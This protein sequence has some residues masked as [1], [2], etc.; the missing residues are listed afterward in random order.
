[1]V[2]KFYMIA[3]IAFMSSLCFPDV[4]KLKT[5]TVVT[6]L[7]YDMGI[8][9]RNSCVVAP[10]YAKNRFVYWNTSDTNTA[11]WTAVLYSR[12]ELA[13]HYI[14]IERRTVF[15]ISDFSIMQSV[16]YLIN[17]VCVTN[18][19]AEVF[20]FAVEN[21]GIR[22]PGRFALVKFNEGGLFLYAVYVNLATGKAGLDFYEISEANLLLAREVTFPYLTKQESRYQ[23]HIIKD[24]KNSSLQ[25]RKTDDGHTR[26]NIYSPQYAPKGHCRMGSAGYGCFLDYSFGRTNFCNDSA[27]EVSDGKDKY[28][29]VTNS[30]IPAYN[31]FTHVALCYDVNS[32]KL[33]K[34]KTYRSLSPEISAEECVKVIDSISKNC[35]YFYGVK[36]PVASAS[37]ISS[38]RDEVSVNNS[39]LWVGENTDGTFRIKIS[40]FAKERHFRNI[41]LL[42]ESIK[43]RSPPSV[44]SKTVNDVKVDIDL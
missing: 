12:Y 30:I 14:P 35:E 24:F 37:S 36:V 3:F 16:D 11:L 15:T 27:I 40:V 1:M 34:L 25:D 10:N 6:N 38:L 18:M 8:A 19:D 29:C 7:V 39:I 5:I 26:L 33:F 20:T 4:A 23:R 17:H 9:R 41:E 22:N 43:V 28:L 32:R 44:K 13:E 31:Q 42:I 21:P 2:I